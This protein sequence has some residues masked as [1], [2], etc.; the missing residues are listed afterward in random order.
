M[1]F[2]SKNYSRK[3]FLIKKRTSAR[4]SHGKSLELSTQS[5]FRSTSTLELFI[6]LDG[7]SLSILDEGR[8]RMTKY[9]SVCVRVELCNM[10]LIKFLMKKVVV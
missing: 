4:T 6:A 7:D 5:D 10:P 8:E 2:Y 9:V 3:Y 1:S